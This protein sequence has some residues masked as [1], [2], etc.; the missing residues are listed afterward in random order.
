MGKSVVIKS[1]NGTSID[2]Y[3]EVWAARWVNPNNHD[4]KLDVVYE[5]ESPSDY[6]GDNRYYSIAGYH[7]DVKN[8]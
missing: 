5:G 6:P 8:S 4:E 7:Y 3:Y 2:C 1:G